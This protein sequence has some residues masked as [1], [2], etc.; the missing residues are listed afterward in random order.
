MPKICAVEK[1]G[2]FSPV[3]TTN[4]EQFQQ[5]SCATR[6]GRVGTKTALNCDLLINVQLGSSTLN[7]ASVAVLEP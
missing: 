3:K 1:L 2:I 4:V 5:L 6:S 7:I